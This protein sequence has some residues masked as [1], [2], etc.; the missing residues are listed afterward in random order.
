MAAAGPLQSVLASSRYMGGRGGSR[1]VCPSARAGFLCKGDVAPS[2]VGLGVPWAGEWAAASKLSRDKSG[3][4]REHARL[5]LSETGSPAWGR[6][7]AGLH[8]VWCSIGK[9]T[10]GKAQKGEVGSDGLEWAPSS[11]SLALI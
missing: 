10:G 5:G 6:V 4:R 3:L 8:R 1:W 9:E 7:V 11:C 2:S